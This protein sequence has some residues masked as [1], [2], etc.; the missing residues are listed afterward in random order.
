MLLLMCSLSLAQNAVIGEIAPD[1]TLQDS[2][3]DP[4]TL[5]SFYNIGPIVVFFYPNDATKICHKE[6]LAFRN[7]TDELEKYNTTIIGISSNSVAEHNDTVVNNDIKYKLLTDFDNKVRKQWKVPRSLLFFPGR[8][9]YILDKE[10]VVR[11][12]HK[13]LLDGPGHADF[14][15]TAVKLIAKE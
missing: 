12:I 6:I 9:T 2:N 1:F 3:D 13:D 10:G 8:V 11:Y 5:S 4:T 15:L 14:A 7:L